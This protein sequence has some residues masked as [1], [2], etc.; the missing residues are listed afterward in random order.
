MNAYMVVG[1]TK[2]KPRFFR[3][4]ESAFDSGEVVIDWRASRVS[5]AGRDAASASKR[6]M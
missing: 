2:V 4:F 6:Q 5:R 1:P 3:S